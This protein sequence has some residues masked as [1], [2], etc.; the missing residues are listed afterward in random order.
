MPSI[1]LDHLVLVR[2]NMSKTRVGNFNQPY[3]KLLPN[4]LDLKTDNNEQLSFIDDVDLHLQIFSS[5]TNFKTLC[6]AD[7][8]YIYTFEHCSKSLTQKLFYN[9][10]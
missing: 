3:K 2:L 4:S 6:Y 7:I 8:V 5:S 9:N 1:E 10:D